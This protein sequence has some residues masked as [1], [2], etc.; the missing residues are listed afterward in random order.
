MVLGDKTKLETEHTFGID[1]KTLDT[2]YI[3]R[4]INDDPWD[5]IVS[6]NG[7]KFLMIPPNSYE[8]YNIAIMERDESSKGKWPQDTVV[9]IRKSDTLKFVFNL[10]QKINIKTNQYGDETITRTID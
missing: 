10:E 1:N 9:L 6:I 7:E 2:L 3:E 5:K 8:V 4:P